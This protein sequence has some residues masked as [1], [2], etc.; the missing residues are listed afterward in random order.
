MKVEIN[1]KELLTDYYGDER[2]FEEKVLEEVVK[3][4]GDR[5]LN[6]REGSKVSKAVDDAIEKIRENTIQEAKDRVLGSLLNTIDE[7]YEK[8]DN[9]G[10]VTGRTTLRD[11]YVKAIQNELVYE[12]R[13]SSY[14]Q[15]TF[16]KSVKESV[17]T[18]VEKFREEYNSLVNDEFVEDAM[19][20]AVKKLKERLKIE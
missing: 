6:V 20:Y 9:W 5:I 4:V 1:I 19:E 12:P 18:E 10:K 7:E 11:E 15:N 8:V 14:D 16:T 3:Y 13:K 17:R 2:E